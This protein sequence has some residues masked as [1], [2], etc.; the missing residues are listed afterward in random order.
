M[1]SKT[2][3]QLSVTTVVL[4]ADLLATYSGSGPLK[5]I[6]AA[7]VA[8]Y[9]S[10]KLGGTSGALF[11]FL[12]GLNTW[13]ANQTH[14][15][16]TATTAADYVTLKPTDYGVGKPA[17]VFSKETTALNWKLRIDD[18]S[19]VAGQLNLVF[20]LLN[21]TGA[22]TVSGLGTFGSLSVTGALTLTGAV[23]YTGSAIGIINTG[24]G[25]TLDCSVSDFHQRSISANTTYTLQGGV[26]GKSAFMIAELTITSAAIPTFTGAKWENGTA[27][28]PGNG[29]ADFG[30]IWNGTDWTGVLL[31][32]AVA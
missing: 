18:G 11:G 21:V 30:F 13:S 23:T 32:V 4:D 17:L 3:P 22:L 19:T 16:N 9:L 20:T 28:N 2:Y 31:A 14:S 1:A 12:N 7:N 24:G 15:V 8:A 10:A 25:T 5:Q 6:T 26:A 27:P 29:R